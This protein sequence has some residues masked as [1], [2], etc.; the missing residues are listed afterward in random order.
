MVGWWAFDEGAGT[1]AQDSVGGNDGILNG[2]PNWVAGKV[3]NHALDLDGDGDYVSVSSPSIALDADTT[4]CMWIKISEASAANLLFDTRDPALTS[5]SISCW[6]DTV[7][8]HLEVAGGGSV[9]KF[10]FNAGLQTW[11]HVAVVHNDSVD[12]VNAYVDGQAL[13]AVA[14]CCIEPTYRNDDLTIGSRADVENEFAGQIDDLRIYNYALTAEEVMRVQQGLP[15]EDRF[16]CTGKPDADLNYDC[17]VNF[18]D[19]ARFAVQ[20][21]DTCP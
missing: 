18:L 15:L 1:T 2:D 11:Y 12:D 7:D 14:G 21:M 9:K 6:L 4:Y 20:W 10:A 13:N 5:D 16:V 8:N 3:G 19:F 17:V